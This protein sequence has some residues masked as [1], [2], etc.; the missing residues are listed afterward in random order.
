MTGAEGLGLEVAD[1]GFGQ[2][3]V[4][5]S[6]AAAGEHVHRR[7]CGQRRLF[8]RLGEG[9]PIGAGHI[10]VGDDQHRAVFDG[11]TTVEEV[12]RETQDGF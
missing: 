8:E 12:A 9:Q 5:E 3:V 11:H 1:V 2:L 10:Q 4:G 6:M 7:F